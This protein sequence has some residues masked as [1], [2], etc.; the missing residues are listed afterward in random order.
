MGKRFGGACAPDFQATLDFCNEMSQKVQ[1]AQE[2]EAACR[3]VQLFLPGFDLGTMPN[4]LSRSSLFAPVAKGV[5]TFYRQAVMVT[6]SD[7][8]LEYTGE[9][10]DE[11]DAEIIMVLIYLARVLP[12]GS[13]IPLN[14]SVV[15]RTL[16]RDDGHT[17][18]EWLHRRLKAMREA[19]FFLEAKKRDGSTRYKIG[20]TVSFN[21]LKELTYDD[22]ANSY[23][24]ALDPRWVQLF[25]N[26]EYA[27]LD[28][29]KKMQIKRGLDM[30]KTL[31]RLIA[32]SSDMIQRFPL[33]RLKA[34]M[35][36]GGRMRDYRT[37]LTR[38][39][40]ELIRLGIIANAKIEINTRQEEQLVVWLPELVSA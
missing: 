14:R 2:F 16:C 39:A 38:A 23:S 1:S 35:V 25:S 30:A 28:W 36:Y 27:L 12:L 29:D 19:T 9:Q 26:R 40:A 11:A 5:R 24:F 4:H 8:V 22:E 31:Q 21:I 32:T 6:R 10:L 3:K 13:L 37:A 20:G 33:E 17:Q 34:Q 18:Y 7:C 15:L